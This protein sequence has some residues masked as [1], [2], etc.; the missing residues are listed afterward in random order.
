[1]N[2][3]LRQELVEEIAHQSNYKH[4]I[5]EHKFEENQL[6]VVTCVLH[7]LLA[8]GNPFL[9]IKLCLY[10]KTLS[11]LGRFPNLGWYWSLT[12]Y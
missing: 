2:T 4:L 10:C 3:F 8:A 9:P 7:G 12:C 6:Q 5:S 1:M 11:V